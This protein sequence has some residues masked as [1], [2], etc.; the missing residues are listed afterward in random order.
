MT[1]IMKSK[2]LTSS[3]AL[4]ALIVSPVLQ[5]GDWGK[6]PVT[7][8]AP[9]EECVDLGGSITTGYMSDFIFQGSRHAGDTV[10]TDVKYTIDSFFV[11]VTVGATYYNFT[12]GNFENGIFG[13]FLHTYASFNLGS[14]AG[15][16]TALGYNHVFT[17]EGTTPF[18]MS[19]QG[20]VTLNL[21]RDLGFAALL[22]GTAYSTSGEGGGLAN[23]S[24]GWYH[25]GGLERSFGIT[26]DI[27]L[28]LGVGV[29]YSDNYW[30]HF[31]NQGWAHYYATASLPIK[32]N[33]RTTLTPYVGFNGGMD[34]NAFG[35]ASSDS[36]G[37]A[38]G[39]DVL[40]GGLNISVSF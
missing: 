13:D 20:V 37:T 8:K 33:C 15:F 27:S 35:F 23:F 29:G 28:V 3:I 32:L 34:D 5:A 22:L 7:G 36:L 16:D 4:G 2:V 21:R 9:I 1:T 19:S 14:I 39:G 11:P 18:D 40:H 24:G 10:W 17:P 31:F 25:S 38:G 6:A 30:V 26:D 12:N